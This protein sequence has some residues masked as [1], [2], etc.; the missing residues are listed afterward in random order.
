LASSEQ[1]A[2]RFERWPLVL[3]A[4]VAVALGYWLYAGH[5]TISRGDIARLSFGS[6]IGEMNLDGKRYT[7]TWSDDARTFAGT[8][9][10]TG[11][12]AQSAVPLITHEVVVTTG[13]Y[14]DPKVVQIQPLEDHHTTWKYV[15]NR[16]AVGTIHIV[17]CIP[18]TPE[19]YDALGA[20]KVGQA[21]A[22][23]G[24]LLQGPLK[25]TDGSFWQTGKES[26]PTVFVRAVRL[27][28]APP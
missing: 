11:Q 6:T 27:E 3:A 4:L 20:L 19:I 8:I 21:V 23:E 26:H 17:H 2:L 5:K 13:E 12:A 9:Q 25:G 18:S 22:I 10:W 15:A 1:T 24:E 7:G 14:S 16:M 28:P